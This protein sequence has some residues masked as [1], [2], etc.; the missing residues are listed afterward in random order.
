MAQHQ[1]LLAGDLTRRLELPVEYQVEGDRVLALAKKELARGKPPLAAGR[2]EPSD[3]VV[4]EAD[5]DRGAAEAVG[6]RA[7]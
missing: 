1:D 6:H 3:L 7:A 5:E 4:V 2:G